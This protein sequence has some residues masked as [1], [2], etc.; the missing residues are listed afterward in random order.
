MRQWFYDDVS[1]ERSS[2]SGR[3]MH[4]PN[5]PELFVLESLRGT[6]EDA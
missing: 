2:K 1:I 3:V 6:F 5:L 4:I